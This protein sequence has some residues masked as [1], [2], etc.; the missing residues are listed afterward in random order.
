M[1]HI[2]VSVLWV[3]LKGRSNTESSQPLVYILG[4]NDLVKDKK[5]LYQGK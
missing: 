3:K 4:Q 5:L 1:V 2:V